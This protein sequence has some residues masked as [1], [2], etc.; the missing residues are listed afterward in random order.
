MEKTM[1]VFDMDQYEIEYVKVQPCMIG[2]VSYFKDNKKNK[3]YKRIKEKMIGEYIGRYD[4]YTDS[5]VTDIPDS[6]D[7]SE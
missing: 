7:E 5:I 3:V 6:D 2:N 1:E 4:P